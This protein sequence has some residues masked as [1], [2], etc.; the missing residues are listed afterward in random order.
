MPITAKQR[1]ERQ[2]YLCA[3][4]SP[5]ILGLSPYQ[6]TPGDVYFSKVYDLPESDE[7]TEAQATGN[8]LEAPL[9]DWAA[10]ELG[11]VQLIRQP[12]F[13]AQSGPAAGV[14]AAHP[15][16]VLR[17]KPEGIEAKYANAAM[18]QS[19][20]DEGTDAIPE[21]VV[22][23]AQHQMYAAELDKVW[24]PVALAGFALSFK[25]FCV[26]RDEDLVSMIVQRGM[27]WWQRHIVARVPP[28]GDDVPPMEIL[29]RVRREPDMIVDLP[30]EAEK[31]VFDWQQAGYRRKE[32][33]EEH[34][35]LKA[36]LV[37]LL[38]PAEAGR[39]TDGRLVT[40]LEQ[41]FAPQTNTKLLRA[42]HPDLYPRY[43]RE[44]RRRVLRIKEVKKPK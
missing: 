16:A 38:G 4:D 22:V 1:R 13:V 8:L 25:L 21:H 26:P 11:G 43:V 14:F 17:D 42:E 40:F 30:A 2:K 7:P 24:V 39:L 35:E 12:W 34:E 41:N 37:N 44:P 29:K 3:S 23:Q 18:G 20:G 27:E 6:R 28:E 9:L 5:I 36:R 33:D 31:L 19:Y 15:D 10:A 32:A